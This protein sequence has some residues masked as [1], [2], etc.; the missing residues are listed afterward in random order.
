MFE[1]LAGKLAV[2][3]NNSLAGAATWGET[4]DEAGLERTLLSV[5]RDQEHPTGHAGFAR[6]VVTLGLQLQ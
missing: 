3:S 5:T 4:V 1:R 6:P 2:G